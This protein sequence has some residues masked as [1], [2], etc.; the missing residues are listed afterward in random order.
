MFRLL[1]RI[2]KRSFSRFGR[3]VP[4][5][6]GLVGAGLDTYLLKRIADHARLE[7]PEKSRPAS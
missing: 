7:F 3:V 4:V 2:G 5:A 6:G 1:A